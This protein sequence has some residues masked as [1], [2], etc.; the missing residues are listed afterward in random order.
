MNI[1][2]NTTEDGLEAVYSV[3]PLGE[4]INAKKLSNWLTSIAEFYGRDDLILIVKDGELR[5]KL[6]ADPNKK[7]ARS[8]SYI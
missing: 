7:V 8:I 3:L 6:N 4:K 2:Y 5:A 1:N